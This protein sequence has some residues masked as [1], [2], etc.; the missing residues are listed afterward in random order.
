M[1]LLQTAI[2][3]WRADGGRELCRYAG[4]KY[5]PKETYNYLL[6]L[7]YR[8]EGYTA[9]GD[10]FR[11]YEVS[12]NDLNYVSTYKRDGI[13]HIL[14]G[15]WHEQC[16]PFEETYRYSMFKSHFDQGVPWEDTAEF[17]VLAERLRRTGSIGTLDLPAQ[18]QSVEQLKQYYEYIDRLYARI[19]RHGYER[20][21]T[22][23][24]SDDFAGRTISPPLN[25]IQVCVGPTGRLLVKSGY[26]RY[27]IAKLLGVKTVPVRTQIRHKNWQHIRESIH[28]GDG[29]DQPD[30][31]LLR[32]SDHSEL[33][34][35]V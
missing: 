23:S 30:S 11:V 16:K 2:A 21:S 34:D 3:K 10:P 17:Q 8:A 27:T 18:E 4:E 22:L 12:P 14:D 33:A 24:S 9:I 13:F 28:R 26:H 5:L 35:L 19:K 32:Y 1:A 7:R 15:D 31:R 6:R 29:L 25:E 20:Q